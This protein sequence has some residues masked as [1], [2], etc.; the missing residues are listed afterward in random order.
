MGLRAEDLTQP[1]NSPS[2]YFLRSMKYRPTSNTSISTSS[3]TRKSTAT[4]KRRKSTRQNDSV[5]N[6]RR[7]KDEKDD[8]EDILSSLDPFSYL[9]TSCP[10]A[11]VYLPPTAL[12]SSLPDKLDSHFFSPFHYREKKHKKLAGNASSNYSAVEASRSLQSKTLSAARDVP[13]T[14]PPS[15]ICHTPRKMSLQVSGSMDNWLKE[16]RSLQQ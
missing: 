16:H 6:Q 5:R 15:P 11:S 14:P 8:D 9:S 3:T 1:I 7:Y 13:Q 4:R 12:S 10:N 2:R